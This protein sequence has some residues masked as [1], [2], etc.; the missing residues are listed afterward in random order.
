MDASGWRRARHPAPLDPRAADSDHLCGVRPERRDRRRLVCADDRGVAAVAPSIVREMRA[1]DPNVAPYEF[2]TM[3]EQID[4][5]TY[6]QRMAVTLVGLFGA[7]AL[8]LAAIGVY[9]VVAFAVSQSTREL[10]L[11]L[12]LGASPSRLLTFVVS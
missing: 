12:A 8:G 2:L 7:L 4:R 6:A 10:G 9:G 5:S 11:R 1:I 3:Q